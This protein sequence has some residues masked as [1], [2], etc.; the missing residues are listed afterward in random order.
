MSADE[1]GAR[2]HDDGSFGRQGTPRA[3]IVSTIFAARS[4]QEGG[5]RDHPGFSRALDFLVR[6]AVVDGGCS[7]DGRRDSV[8]SCYTGMLARLLVRADRLD[9]AEPLLGWIL[10]YQPVAFGGT[11]YR[12]PVGPMWGDYLRH[13]YGGCMADTTCLLGLVP[14]ISALVTARDSGMTLDADAQLGAMRQFQVDRR[15]MFGRSGAI[16]PLAGRT[17]ADPTG[18][19]WLEP[20]FPL[21]YLVD[22]VELVGLARQL[23]VPPDSMTEAVDLIGSWRL[24]DGGWPLLRTR[25]LIDA[26][27]PEPVNRRCSSRIITRRV[28]DLDLTFA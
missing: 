11:T 10:R 24:P 7:I 1:L 18:T 26:Y 15:M 20:A 3:R 25:R 13:R 8:L 21:D 22:L 6:N 2:Q 14:T 23:G 27:R 4:L 17:K 12:E 28:A 16:M 19:R 9:E 5:V